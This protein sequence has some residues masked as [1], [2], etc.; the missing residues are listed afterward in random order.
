MVCL[1]SMVIKFL[2]NDIIFRPIVEEANSIAPAF[3]RI[4]K[5]LILVADYKKPFL[6]AGKGTVM[7]KATLDLYAQEVEVL[8]VVIIS[9]GSIQY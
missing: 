4:F 7:R 3:S 2:H 9:D 6:R 5:E 8:C 1:I